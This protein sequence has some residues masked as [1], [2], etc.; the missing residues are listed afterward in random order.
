MTER[1]RD[2]AHFD[3]LYT[4]SDDPWN[5]RASPYERAKYS[6]TIAALPRCR[7]ARG[8]EVG[9]SIGE[10]TRLL[11]PAC[12]VMLGL[13][14]AEAPLAAAR[15]RCA[16]MAWVD[17]VRMTVPAEWPDGVFDLIVLSEML[18]FLSP[19]DVRSVAA[20]V[21]ASLGSGGTVLLVNFLGQTND[22]GTGD[23]A[24]CGFIAASRLVPDLQ[25][26]HEGYR[27]DRLTDAL[28]GAP[29]PGPGAVPLA[30]PKAE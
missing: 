24:A 27:L 10:L 9:C 15:R 22:P 3:R 4:A 19:D 12:D 5:F 17:F 23:S 8:L 28:P 18:Y 16:D 25:Q 14:F 26:R 21:D 2:V 7:F 13:D 11:A 1:S 29:G 6:S 20:R 30:L